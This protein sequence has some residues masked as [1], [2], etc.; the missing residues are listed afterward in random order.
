MKFNKYFFKGKVEFIIRK[1]KF[2][3]FKRDEELKVRVVG[4]DCGVSMFIFTWE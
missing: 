3:G 1:G 2:L 4:W